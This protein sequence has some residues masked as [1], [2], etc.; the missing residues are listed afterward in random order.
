VSHP[1]PG[2]PVPHHD[3]WPELVGRAFADSHWSL[4]DSEVRLTDRWGGISTPSTPEALFNNVRLAVLEAEEAD[5]VIHETLTRHRQR[6]ADFAWVVGPLCRPIDL[7]ERLISH[8]MTPM[9]ESWGMVLQ[10]TGLCQGTPDG[11]T[12]ARVGASHIDDFVTASQRGWGQ[13][14]STS[15][16]FRS[17]V[18][19]ALQQHPDTLRAYVAYDHG[20]PAGAGLMRLHPQCAL[21]IGSSV[22]PEH[23]G[24]HLYRS[25]LAKRLTDMAQAGRSLAAV[26][27]KSTTAGPICARLGFERV[28][29]F[30]DFMH[31]AS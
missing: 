22:A 26:V 11:V 25:L 14:T 21:L 23:R 3:Q 5:T 31:S 10:A 8:G 6:G 30:R 24:R 19:R 12:V 29:T 2:T 27:A 9:G 17:H 15:A 28:C 18:L 16:S 13:P 7:E 20:T 1:H 4:Q